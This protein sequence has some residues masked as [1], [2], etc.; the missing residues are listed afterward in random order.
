MCDQWNCK[1]PW[2]FNLM[3]IILVAGDHHLYTTL[4]LVQL[5]GRLSYRLR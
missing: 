5:F 2:Q 1:N 3:L 4:L